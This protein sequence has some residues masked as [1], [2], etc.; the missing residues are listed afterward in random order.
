MIVEKDPEVETLVQ[1]CAQQISAVLPLGWAF[2]VVLFPG[3][4]RPGACIS[5]LN[6]Q[7]TH[8]QLL[9]FIQATSEES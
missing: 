4:G 3:D 5:A 7:E 6:Q 9:E 2:C 8:L 1:A